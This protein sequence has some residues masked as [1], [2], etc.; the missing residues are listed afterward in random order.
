MNRS[1]RR[2]NTVPSRADIELRARRRTYIIYGSLVLIA[3]LAIVAVIVVNRNGSVQNAAVAPPLAQVSVGQTAPTFS[4]STTAGAFDLSAAGG[5]PTLLEVFATWCPH[6]QR[7]VPII[8]NLYDH[9]K[10]QV[11][12]VGVSG[13][14]YAM[15]Q[16][17]ESQADVVAFMAKYGVRYPMAFDPDLAVAKE[18]L[19]GGFPTIV[20]I[21]RDGKI[22]AIG[23]GEVQGKEM[24]KAMTAALAGKPVDPAFGQNQKKK[25]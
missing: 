25:S 17:A 7:E 2:R 3:V 4:V 22:L 1:E 12:F 6:C 13:S 11:N 21:G 19:Q 15:D 14:P 20:L 5:K 8:G 23:S 10:S 24:A 18:Y 9:F 16:T